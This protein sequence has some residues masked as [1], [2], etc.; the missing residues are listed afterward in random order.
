[1]KTAI[2][3]TPDRK[4]FGPA[5]CVAAQ[6]I[7]AGIP[8]EADVVILCEETDI[9]PGYEHLD[10]KLSERIKLITA[11]FAPMINHAPATPQGS[12]AIYRRLVLDRVLPEKYERFIAIDSDIAIGREGLTP[13][14]S[15]I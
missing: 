9:W 15:S 1:M 12:R 13:L 2:C 4:F 3:L 7:A 5:V 10:A 8:D 14:V 6:A 11:D